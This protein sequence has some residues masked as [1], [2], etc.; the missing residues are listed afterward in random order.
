MEMPNRRF[1]TPPPFVHH[2]ELFPELSLKNPE[3]SNFELRTKN[4][5]L[6]RK[7][8][9]RASVV[10]TENQRVLIPKSMTPQV[11]AHH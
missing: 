6:R 5:N 3:P 10:T 2:P 9:I 7:Q 1:P 4:R 8:P 11:F